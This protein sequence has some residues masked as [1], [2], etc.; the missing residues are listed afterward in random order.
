VN[1]RSLSPSFPPT[2]NLKYCDTYEELVGSKAIPS[3]HSYTVDDV[4]SSKIADT[5]QI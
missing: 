5:V 3:N 1:R 2:H 4:F